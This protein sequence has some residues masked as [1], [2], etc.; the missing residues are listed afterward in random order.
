MKGKTLLAPHPKRVYLEFN[1]VQGVKG[2]DT[3]PWLQQHDFCFAY[4]TVLSLVRP[5]GGLTLQSN[6]TDSAKDRNFEER[7]IV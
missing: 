5:P 3:D 7:G 1:W 6:V 4:C 2:M